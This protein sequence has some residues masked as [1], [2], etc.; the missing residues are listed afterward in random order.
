[1]QIDAK[2]I[3][4]I[5]TAQARLGLSDDEYRAILAG[6]YQKESC[7]ALTYTEAS[8]LIDYFKTL[9][10]VIPP[11]K[12]YTAASRRG[13]LPGNVVALPTRAQLDMVDALAGKIAWRFDDGC[14]RWLKKYHRIDRIKTDQEA[15]NVIE[16]LKKL[17]DHQVDNQGDMHRKPAGIG[18][19]PPTEGA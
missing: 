8:R 19:C 3:K 15:S 17:L 10:F 1:M 7:K 9:G 2:Q 5:K 12:R 16:G 18:T 11:R 13:P 6:R 4:I 14:Q